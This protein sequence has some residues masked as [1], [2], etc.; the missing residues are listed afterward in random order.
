MAASRTMK[1]GE[2]RRA[3]VILR[4]ASGQSYRAIM[5]QESCS[6][7]FIARWKERFFKERLAGL[8]ARHRGKI[9]SEAIIAQEA[10]I[11]RTTK[12][13]PPDGSTH[14]S[15]RRLAEHLGVSHSRVARGWARAGIQPHRIRRYM[16]STDPEFEEK[17]ADVIGL[18]LKP[19]LNAAVFCVDEKSA[20]QA[21]DRLDPVLPLS[22]GRAE[23]HGFEYFRHGTLSLYAALDTRTGDVI[24]KTT[25]RHTS[26]E[27]VDFL[28]AI[29]ASQPAG[30]EIH[31]VADNLSAHKTK[32]VFEFLNTN[33]AVRLHY[34]PTYSSWLNQV[35]IWFSKI[36]RAVITRGIFTSKTDLSRKLLRY[37]KQYNKKPP[38]FHWRYKNVDHQIEPN[39]S[40]SL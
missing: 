7:V 36:Q 24:G 2:V 14:W 37:I 16:A 1:A 39:H 25:D 13:A 34:T 29:V 9:V 11:L 27:F 4:L 3:K 30:R 40:T 17:A 22:P 35:E 19:P 5:K 20:I 23:R 8:Y 6:Q 28:S 12:Q 26:V 32:G 21:L 10:R 15:T 33:P 31:I 18:Y 38:P